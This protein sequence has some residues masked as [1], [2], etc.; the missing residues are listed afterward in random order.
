MANTTNLNLSL[1]TDGTTLNNDLLN[2]NFN[3]IDAALGGGGSGDEFIFGSYTGSGSTAS[4]DNPK[5]NWYWTV[6]LGY[7][8]KAVIVFSNGSYAN[9][10]AY[11][12]YPVLFATPDFCSVK[13]GDTWT[14]AD[15]IVITDTGFKALYFSNNSGLQCNIGYGKHYYIVVK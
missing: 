10:Y 9:N 2:T 4:E 3:L 6:E 12:K 15:T 1:I 14:S 11:N 13:A 5:Q 7:K 8:P